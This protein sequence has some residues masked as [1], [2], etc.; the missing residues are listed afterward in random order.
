MDKDHERPEAAPPPRAA[1]L[2]EADLDEVDQASYESFPASD[3]PSWTP[4]AGPGSPSR[5]DETPR[6]CED[7]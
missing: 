5:E 6:K 4:V 2:R 1:K 3:A 7:L